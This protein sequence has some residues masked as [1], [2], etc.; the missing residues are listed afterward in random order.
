MNSFGR[1]YKFSSFG[2]SHG[3]AIGGIIEGLPAGISIDLNKIQ[4]NLNQRRPGHL[5]NTSDRQE[6]DKIN[7]L[8][9]LYQGKTLGTPIGFIITNEDC[10]SSDYESLKDVFRPSHADFTTFSKYGIRDH[11]GGGRSSAREM[12]IRIV[13][14]SVAQQILKT[15]NVQIVAFVSQIGHAI[16]PVSEI[17]DQQE[18]YNSP[19]YCPFRDSEN[20]MVELLEYIKL[21]GDSVGG[22][23][24]CICYGVPIGLG[25]PVYDKL[26]ARLAQS[27]FSINGV[28]GFEIGSGFQC[29]SKKGSEHN[30][31]FYLK[32]N[33]ISTI[34]N[35]SGGIQGGI[36]NGEA[37]NMNIAFK[38]TSSIG[39]TQK[40]IT[41][42]YKNV[43]INISGRH[44][45]CIAIRAVPV[46]IA[47]A[48]CTILDFFL[49]QK[50][51][52][53]SS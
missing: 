37:I 9:G 18:V 11:R 43:E 29:I 48:A 36:S 22:R 32:G 8:S 49:L 38:P 26:S 20:E 5:E 45:P 7:I 4:N 47:M 44:D 33:K 46:V 23:L 35:N 40:T 42:D 53:W 17:K 12:A 30:D 1:I 21:S 16:C 13:A 27:M 25:E 19:V 41:S 39:L 15:L 52:K 14:G 51:A 50:L 10:K 34:T 24:T 6:P 3:D 28:K 2:E 31:S